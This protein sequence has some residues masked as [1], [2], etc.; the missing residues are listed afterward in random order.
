MAFTF[1]K[2]ADT[3][4]GNQR[5]IQGVVTCDSA[6]GAVSVGLNTIRHV[7]VTPKS[8]PTSTDRA[9]VAKINAL[10]VGTALA[11]SLAITGVVSGDDYYVTIYGS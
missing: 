2:S 3:V 9:L 7:D 4:F 1:T 5:V 8:A 11:G 6:A 10:S